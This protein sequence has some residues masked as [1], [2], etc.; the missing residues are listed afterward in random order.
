MYEPTDLAE[1]CKTH[2]HYSGL[3]NIVEKT[4][5]VKTIWTP[6]SRIGLFITRT[7]NNLHHLELSTLAAK[8]HAAD[9]FHRLVLLVRLPD[10][11]PWGCASTHLS[12]LA[13]KSGSTVSATDQCTFTWGRDNQRIFTVCKSPG[14]SGERPRLRC[15]L[16]SLALWNDN[17]WIIEHATTTCHCVALKH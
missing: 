4:K 8:R 11:L 15:P 10:L 14:M 12:V 2:L 17:V 5:H 6:K 3:R 7:T 1:F 13:D 9:E 16:G